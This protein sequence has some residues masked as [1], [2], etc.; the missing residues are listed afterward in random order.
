[1]KQF[2][3]IF[4][5]IFLLFSCKQKSKDNTRNSERETPKSSP[6]NNDTKLEKDGYTFELKYNPIKDST[7]LTSKY[8]GVSRE[9]YILSGK[10]NKSFYSDINSD[11][12]KELFISTK[13]KRGKVVLNGYA[14]NSEQLIPIQINE[15]P[16]IGKTNFKS[17]SKS[18][19]QII[20]SFQVMA[21]DKSII[22]KELRY[23]LV[24]S[25]TG[26]TLKPQGYTT[27][28]LK[29][30]IGIYA[31][32]DGGKSKNYK[33]LDVSQ[34]KLG[35]WV[36]EIK[37]RKKNTTKTICNFKTIGHFYD[38]DL[39]V[40]LGYENPEF[41]GTLKISFVEYVASIYTQD[42]DDVQEMAAFCNNLASLAGN[43]KKQ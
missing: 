33:T 25:E 7:L 16:G 23:N 6:I 17:F 9:T 1:M 21:P 12:N 19:N 40:P 14:L 41:S 30:F 24:N 10:M 13:S 11:K 15:I 43:F 4:L 22:K 8:K 2:V 20:E 5:C 18:R 26:L 42:T 27:K 35:E 29:S 37:V 28:Q 36:V 31:S 34:N 38:R 32:N 3:Y 39:Y